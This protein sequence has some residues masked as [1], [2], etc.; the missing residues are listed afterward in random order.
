[1]FQIQ[2]ALHYNPILN[3]KCTQVQNFQKK[4]LLETKKQSSK[5]GLK[6]YKMPVMMV[7]DG[8]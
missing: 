2:Y 8:F 6:I 5:M 4:T 1:M 3:T 7:R